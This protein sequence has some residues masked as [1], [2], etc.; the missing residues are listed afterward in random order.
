MN[1]N[2]Q[3]IITAYKTITAVLCIEA[4]ASR[5]RNVFIESF[6][7]PIV[8]TYRIVVAYSSFCI[9]SR[10]AGVSIDILFPKPDSTAK[11]PDIVPPI[12]TNWGLLVFSRLSCA[13]IST[14]GEGRYL[15]ESLCAL[16]AAASIKRSSAVR[17]LLV[18]NRTPS[19]IAVQRIFIV[20]NSQR[21]DVSL[22]Y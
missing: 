1:A 13:A 7:S 21:M 17:G 5:S 20:S 4:Q 11:D 6:E 8:I 18:A 22:A 16:T 3:D 2:V 12:A 14:G 19:L 15:W 10:S 9:F